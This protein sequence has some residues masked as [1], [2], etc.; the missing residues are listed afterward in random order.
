MLERLI[1][2][3]VVLVVIAGCAGRS[4]TESP[5]APDAPPAP[6]AT[7]AR[8]ASGD[9]AEI[10]FTQ[11]DAC[12]NDG[13]VE[14]C[15]PDD[16]PAVLS[17]LSTISSTISCAPGGGRARCLATPGLLLCSYPTAVPT[18][19]VTPHGAMTDAAWA[20]MCA[21]AALPQVTAIVPTIYE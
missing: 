18:E 8:C 12:G 15:V 9:T 21:I 17:T 2:V 4:A 5:G 14:F 7:L 13:S 1:G 11:A 20:D 19:C 16:D 6:D 10:K 3:G